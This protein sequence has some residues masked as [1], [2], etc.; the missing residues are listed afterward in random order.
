MLYSFYICSK[1]FNKER[2]VDS[3]VQLM[4]YFI[5]LTLILQETYAKGHVFVHHSTTYDLFFLVCIKE[6]HQLHYFT[7]PDVFPGLTQNR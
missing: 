3:L 4:L 6:F 1:S 2:N 7:C 5:N